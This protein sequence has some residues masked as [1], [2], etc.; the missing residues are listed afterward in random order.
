M[1]SRRGEQEERR[2]GK[3]R[4]EGNISRTARTVAPLAVYEREVISV[5]ARWVGSVLGAVLGQLLQ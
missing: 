4:W 1:C 2:G 3:L 5:E